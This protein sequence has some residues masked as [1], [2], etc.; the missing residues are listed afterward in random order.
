[1]L[2]VMK[3]GGVYMRIPVYSQYEIQ[4]A[5]WER[6]LLI[7]AIPRKHGDASSTTSTQIHRTQHKAIQ[8]QQQQQQQQQSQDPDY[9][10][11]QFESDDEVTDQ[12]R[13]YTNPPSNSRPTQIVK[14]WTLHPENS[15][16]LPSYTLSEDL[17]TSSS[18]RTSLQIYDFDRHHNITSSKLVSDLHILILTP[19]KNAEDVLRHFFALVE[20]LDHPKENMSIGLL[21]GDEED[22]TG[23]M[24]ND[25]AVNQEKK[26]E[27]RKITLLKKDF[28]LPHPNG[29]D[30]HKHWLQA[31]RRCVPLL[32]RSENLA[33]T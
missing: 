23:Q 21:V 11:V 18:G 28:G 14:P 25:W 24:V 6:P 7:P 22:E 16:A 5:G 32:R 12:E 10:D 2:V 33:D 17:S 4:E 15:S 19:L 31:Q 20:N 1:M 13:E 26:G 9:V 30:R 3:F 27:Y 8:N 29:E